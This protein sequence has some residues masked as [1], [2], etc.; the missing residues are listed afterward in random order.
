MDLI[1]CPECGKEIESTEGQCPGCGCPIF[2]QSSSKQNEKQSSITGLQ[3]VRNML[4][5]LAIA[6]FVVSGVFFGKGY[7]VKN[8]Y[9]N[10]EYSIINK[11]AYVGGDAYNYIINGTYFTGYSVIAS[12][13]LLSGMILISDSIKITVKIKEYE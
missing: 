5:V 11:N 1:K 10:S 3:P 9:R 6:C 8:E 7:N 2:D 4:I 12:A 13:A